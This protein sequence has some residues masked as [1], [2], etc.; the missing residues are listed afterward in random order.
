MI[1]IKIWLHRT[2]NS[3]SLHQSTFSERSNIIYY[4]KRGF[5]ERASLLCT[6]LR[7]QCI[8]IQERELIFTL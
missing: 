6:L 1:K 4:F 2:R 8:H 5:S 3:E 7:R